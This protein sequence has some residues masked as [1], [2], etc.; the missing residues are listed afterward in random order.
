MLFARGL[1]F[2]ALRLLLTASIFVAVAADGLS[3]SHNV[4]SAT[5]V[6]DLFAED[7]E[8]PIRTL[9]DHEVCLR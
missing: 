8:P 5:T 7:L 3:A 9:D 6:G 2:G 1:S 4:A